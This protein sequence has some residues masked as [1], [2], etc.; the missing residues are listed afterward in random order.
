MMCAV[1]SPYVD[2]LSARISE[3]EMLHS[4]LDLWIN[5]LNTFLYPKQVYFR[6][7]DG[8]SILAKGGYPLDTSVLSSGSATF[9]ILM[10]KAFMLRSTGGLMVIDEPELLRLIQAGKGS[11]LPAS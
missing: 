7:G 3:I 2:S 5:N 10:T 8:M 11:C 6:V 9:L 4:H 1:L